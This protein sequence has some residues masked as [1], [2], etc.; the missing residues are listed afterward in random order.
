MSDLTPFEHPE[1]QLA[2]NL[3]V[4]KKRLATARFHGLI[5]GVDWAM[6]RGKVAYAKAG[7]AKLM[8]KL[9]LGDLQPEAEMASEKKVPAANLTA[10]VLRTFTNRHLLEAELTLEDGAKITVRVMVRDSKNFK[11][12]MVLPLELKAGME[13]YTLT[14]KEPRWPGKW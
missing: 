6:V 2:K 7:M 11:R 13:L 8:G 14:R 4:K 9:G 10:V 3:G 12:G 5:E 1:A